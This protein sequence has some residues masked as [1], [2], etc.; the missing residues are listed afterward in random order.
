VRTLVAANS[1]APTAAAGPGGGS[2][3]NSRIGVAAITATAE[4]SPPLAPLPA[5]AKPVS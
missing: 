2:A 4:L 1:G 3:Q 5:V